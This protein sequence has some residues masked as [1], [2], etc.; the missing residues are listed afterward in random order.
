MR[1]LHRPRSLRL[2]SFRLNLLPKSVSIFSYKFMRQLRY[3]RIYINLS[4][5]LFLNRL[6]ILYL[7]MPRPRHRILILI[8]HLQRVI[9]VYLLNRFSNRIHELRC[10]Y[11]FINFQLIQISR[12][13]VLAR[14]DLVFGE[15]VFTAFGFGVEDVLVGVVGLAH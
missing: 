10:P 5:S 1:V 14:T 12:E 8:G 15:G 3:P 9:R 4:L 2:I 11:I 6:I 13:L 7:V